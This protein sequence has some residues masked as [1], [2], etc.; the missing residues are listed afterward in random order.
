MLNV[1]EIKKLY[2]PKWS[3]MKLRLLENIQSVI[4]LSPDDLKKEFDLKIKTEE[5]PFNQSIIN[6]LFKSSQTLIY[7]SAFNKKRW[8]ILTKKLKELYSVVKYS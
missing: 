6:R 4:D 2:K 1:K 3:S 8:R 5:P 7:T